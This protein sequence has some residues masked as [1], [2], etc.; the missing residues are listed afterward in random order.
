MDVGTSRLNNG[1]RRGFSRIPWRRKVNPVRDPVRGYLDAVA[2]GPTLI[3]VENTCRFANLGKEKQ[4]AR[5]LRF[6]W[7]AF[8][9]RRCTTGSQKR[10]TAPTSTWVLGSDSQIREASL[11]PPGSGVTALPRAEEDCQVRHRTT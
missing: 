1:I 4:K 3:G 2:C 6:D 9:G 5:S 7:I 11:L 10:R 8:V